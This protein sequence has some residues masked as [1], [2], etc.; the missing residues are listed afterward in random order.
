MLEAAQRASVSKGWAFEAVFTPGAE[1]HAWYGEL[2]EKGVP[3]SVAPRMGTRAACAWVRELTMAHQGP[4]LLHTHFSFWDLPTALGT[5][6]LSVPVVWHLHSRLS[7]ELATRVKNLVRFGLVGRMVERIL[8]VGPEIR[9][10]ALGRLAPARRTQL[11]PNGIDMARFA[12]VTPPEQAAARGRLSLT[13]GEE[14]LLL[15]GWDW[16][17]KGGPLLLDAVAELSR[18][19]RPVLALVV[20][21]PDP[22]RAAAA[23]RGLERNVRVIPPAEDV[24]GLYAA[25]DVFVAASPAEGLPF[26]LLEALSCGTPVVASDI[27]AHR[28]V[29]GGLPGCRLAARRGSDFAEAI[30]AELDAGV[31]DRSARLQRSR[32]LIEDQFALARWSARVVELYEELLNQERG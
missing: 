29:A 3:I 19:G 31:V 22:A 15:F 24:R 7:D 9:A 27:E 4:Q 28:Y 23:R 12:P 16:E 26:S 21:P 11:F 10:K 18:A 1:K 13:A 17:T 2:L 6:G 32:V 20:G 5:R 8:C 14:V 30:A 25:A